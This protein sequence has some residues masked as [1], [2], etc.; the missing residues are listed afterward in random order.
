MLAIKNITKH[1]GS[2]AILHD[3]SL[4]LP[5]GSIGVLLGSSGTGKSTLLRIIAGLEKNDSGSIFLDA[6]Y[7]SPN[8]VGMVFQ[9]F[10]LFENLTVIE[11][12][13][14]ALSKGRTHMP[15]AQADD[16]ARKLLQQYDMLELAQS[17]PEE[18]SGGQQQRVAILRTIAQKP[19]VICF[20]EPTS[21][22][23]PL[24]K[25][26]IARMIIELSQSGYTILVATHDVQLVEQL[27]CTIFLMHA[28]SIVE[29]AD[30]H[31]FKEQPQNFT[32]I[33]KF[34]YHS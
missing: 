6:D 2:K 31:I 23:D 24:L 13:T 26:H 28:G 30:W 20:D 9:Q 1:F 7:L 34:I 12:I 17:L 4:Q 33:K 14:F 16:I 29:I 21:A 11:N 8:K 32:K 3:V 22:L 18:L 27:P 25:T 15:A 5:T 19:A 10:N